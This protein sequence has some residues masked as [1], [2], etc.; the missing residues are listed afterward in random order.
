LLDV[1]LLEVDEGRH[2]V[3][4]FG[5]EVEF[6][7]E[8]VA[9]IELA[10]AP[11]DAL[12]QHALAAAEAVEDLEAA[13][14]PADRAAP[15]RD[16]VVLVEEQDRNPVPREVDRRR[17][18]DRP[19]ADHDHRPPRGLPGIELGRTAIGQPSAILL[20]HLRAALPAT[21]SIRRSADA[22]TSPDARGDAKLCRRR[23]LP[24][25]RPALKARSVRRVVA[26]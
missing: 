5:Q 17:Q 15:G 6:V 2:L 18:P 24:R 23:I 13:L 4:A 19:A 22:A 9:V 25:I 12:G 11:G 7:D 26:L 10:E 20:A 1:E 21:D 8:P 3:P 14:R 16:R